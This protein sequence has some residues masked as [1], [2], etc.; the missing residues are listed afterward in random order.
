MD[1]DQKQ[2]WR[3]AG[4]YSAVGLE[5]GIAIAVGYFLGDWGDRQLDTAPYL[6]ILGVV[7]GAGAGMKALL[8]V[9]RKVNLEKM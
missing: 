5:F 9:A 7:V 2:M 3:L 8:R 4:R 1:R 6:M